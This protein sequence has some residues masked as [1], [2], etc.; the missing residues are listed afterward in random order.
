M[1]GEPERRLLPARFCRECGQEYLHGRAG[2]R[3]ST[4]SVVIAPPR[5]STIQ[6][7][8]TTDTGSST[9]TI[10]PW[11]RRSRCAAGPAARTTGSRTRRRE[12]ACRQAR[13]KDVPVARPCRRRRRRATDSRHR[14]SRSV[15]PGTVQVLPALRR[16]LRVAGAAELGKL[17]TLGTEG[18]SS[19]VTVVAASIV[20]SLQ[21]MPT[22]DIAEDARKLLDLHRQP[23]GRLAAGRTLQRLRPG[24]PAAGGALP[25]ALRSR[26]EFGLDTDRLAA[27]GLEA[28]GLDPPSYARSPGG[29]FDARADATRALRERPGLPAA[30]GSA[31]GW[32]VTLPN[33]EQSGLLVIDYP[34]A[35]RARCGASDCGPAPIRSSQR[36]GGRTTRRGHRRTL[37]DDSGASLAIEV[38]LP[39]RRVV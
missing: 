1:P 15:H 11:P 17:A 35:R 33:L 20:R 25:G 36:D 8:R 6:A 38:G 29:T 7:T 2:P 27:S 28:L 9:S 32:R 5:A 12:P 30:T 24:R 14:C 23:A 39:R 22:A 18:R 34:F 10:S 21:S 37:L 13:R 31:R 4:A 19:A 26:R 3:R 16:E